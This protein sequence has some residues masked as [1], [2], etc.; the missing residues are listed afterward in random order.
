MIEIYNNSDA[1]VPNYNSMHPLVLHLALISTDP[2][3]DRERLEKVGALFVE[4]VKLP[5]G[6]HLVMMKDPWGSSIQFCK[7]GKP[8]DK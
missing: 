2:N 5:D 4:E 7:R 8:F 6:T 1:Q 3:H